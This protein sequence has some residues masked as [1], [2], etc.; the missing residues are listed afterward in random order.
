MG[1]NK[2]EAHD[3]KINKLETR[4]AQKLTSRKQEMSGR[5]VTFM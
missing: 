1:I 3:A 4:D 2:L 5:L